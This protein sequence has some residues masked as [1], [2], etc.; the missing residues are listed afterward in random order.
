MWGTDEKQKLILGLDANIGFECNNRS[1]GYGKQ[2]ALVCLFAE[3]GGRSC[4]VKGSS[5]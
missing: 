3:E 2:Y 4:L 5:V 1:G